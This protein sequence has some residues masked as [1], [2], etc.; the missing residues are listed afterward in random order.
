MLH[1][2]RRRDQPADRF[3]LHGPQSPERDVVSSE[4]NMESPTRHATPVPGNL[5]TRLLRRPATAIAVLWLLGAVATGVLAPLLLPDVATQHAGD[6]ASVR[7]GPSGEHLL[8]TDTLG[9]DVL[10]RLL[11][12]SRVTLLG[13]VEAMIVVL[14]LGL[15]LGLAAGYF[16]GRFDRVV[17]WLADLVFSV[18]AIIIVI[19]VLSVFRSN[20]LAAMCTLGLLQAPALM[21]VVRTATMS[22][23]DQAYIQSAR[24]SGLSG[25]YIISRHVLPRIAGAVIVQASLLACF[26]LTAQTGLAFLNLLVAAPAPSWGGMIADG[27]SV[28]IQDPWLIWPPGIAIA[29]TIISLTQLSDA[30]RD[31]ITQ[32]W[33]G[34]RPPRRAHHRT[35]HG[36]DPRPVDRSG[37]IEQDA[38]LLSISDLSVVFDTPGGTVQ[39]LRD[40]NLSLEKGK[41]LGLVGES[42]C[43]KTITATSILGLLPG[44]GRVSAGAIRFAGHELTALSQRSMRRLRGREIAF[45][46]QHPMSSLDP[47][48]RVGS[49]IREAI[50][51]HHDMTR[52]EA[53][54]RTRALLEA[55]HLPEPQAVA[56]SFPHE[57][58]G[59]MAQRVS[60]A[61]AL[62]G[63]PALLIADEP[64]TALDS[65][66]Q[67]GI[68]DLLREITATRDTS[69][70]LI[71]HDLAVVA[72]V[73]DDVAVMYA[74]EVV[75]RGPIATIFA[76]PVHPYTRALLA[77]NPHN[78]PAGKP[79]QVIPG[80]VPPPGTWPSGC[81]F[82]ARCAFVR[83]EC[84]AGVIP[85]IPLP[86]QR[87]AR[88]IRHDQVSNV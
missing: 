70:L 54:H 86:G 14:A 10:D 45:V 76:D 18:P 47:S 16:R 81:H 74:G 69:V 52:R 37:S 12:G 72:E 61:R 79:L 26:A 59:G 36:P 42:G 87:S 57:L 46:S 25:S 6:L 15:P 39:V 64:T 58:S 27:A 1:D 11:V 28:I 7:Q 51:R 31:N 9:R 48:F 8:G 43:G 77:S 22:V 41:I 66:V 5:V 23:T 65:T 38:A 2:L 56:R 85:M 34:N 40:V 71:T 4:D 55:V 53:R 35:A 19:V 68:L 82:A 75:E 67:S 78:A 44:S 49:Q 24:V 20:M 29:L 62:A 17:G 84:E 30:L 60:I 33:A 73:C 88:C 13:V 3:H 63:D 50:R 21:R 80:S 83:K 32:A